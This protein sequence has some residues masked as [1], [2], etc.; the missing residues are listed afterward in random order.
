MSN[1]HTRDKCGFRVDPAAREEL[2]RVA[3]EWAL[4]CSWREDPEDIAEM[5]D[6]EILHGVNRHYEGGLVQLAR[7]AL[8]EQQGTPWAWEAPQDAARSEGRAR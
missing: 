1:T 6:A 4:D 7:D 2:A 5:S 3:R 8:L